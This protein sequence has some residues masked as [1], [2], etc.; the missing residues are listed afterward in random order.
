MSLKKPL[1]L[2]AGALVGAVGAFKAGRVYNHLAA[3]EGRISEAEAELSAQICR[4]HDLAMTMISLLAQVG[5]E[6][7]TLLRAVGARRAAMAAEKQGPSVRAGAE[8]SLTAALA[9]LIAL[10]LV[11]PEVIANKIF[12]SLQEDIANAE[13]QTS[14]AQRR[15]NAAVQRYNHELATMPSAL[16][17]SRLG[18]YERELFA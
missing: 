1:L 9:D 13:R 4:R 17:A 10:A 18:H 2:A 11:Q 12:A 7:K 16:F 8:D 15:Y 5:A 3:L 14:F 6:E